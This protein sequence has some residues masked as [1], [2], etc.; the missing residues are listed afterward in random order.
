VLA[1]ATGQV[2]ERNARV[3]DVS[4]SSTK[5]FTIIQNGRLELLLK[6]PATDL[7]Q[8]RPGQSVKIRS[9]TNSKLS[10]EG[11][12][13]EIE[14]LVNEESRQ[15]TLRVDLPAEDSLR[16]GMFLRAKI[17]TSAAQ[18]LTVPSK[19]V[20]PQADGSSVVY[21]VQGDGTVK[22][23]P[24]KLGEIMSGD[25]IEIKSGLSMGD[26]VVVKGAPFLKDGDKVEVR[27]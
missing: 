1:P 13:R 5:L 26:R 22:A 4:S 23:Q 21:R 10:I 27:G 3:G 19:A 8:I 20:L 14:P 24:V 18:G 12:V 15:A 6:V 9:E 17:T 7:K 2:A 25:R 11:K 16:P